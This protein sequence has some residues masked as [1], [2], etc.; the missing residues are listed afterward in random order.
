M[1]RL[2]ALLSLAVLCLCQEPSSPSPGPWRQSEL[3]EPSV[4][5]KMLG[6]Q[7]APAVICVAFPFLY[8][9]KHISHSIFAGPG[10]KPEGLQLLK[11]GASKLAKDDD[12]VIYCGCCP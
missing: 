11:A 2:I 5:A 6:H 10:S 4:L 9:G 12:V 7:N 1:V 8:R 3:I